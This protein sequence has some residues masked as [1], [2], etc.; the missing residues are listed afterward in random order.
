M[1]MNYKLQ[2]NLVKKVFV[3]TGS[4]EE[5]AKE[6]PDPELQ[7]ISSDVLHSSPNFPA[8]VLTDSIV[9]DENNKQSACDSKSGT[10][11]LSKAFLK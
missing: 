10:A 5:N 2:S 6:A 1:L 8:I 11:H 9:A 4:L 3:R 7:E